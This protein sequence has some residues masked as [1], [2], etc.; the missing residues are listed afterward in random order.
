[1][2]SWVLA[3]Q[4]YASAPFVVGSKI[5]ASRVSQRG[6]TNTLITVLTA[7]QKTFASGLLPIQGSCPS[8]RSFLLTI[9]RTSLAERGNPSRVL[10]AT[11][12]VMVA[13]ACFRRPYS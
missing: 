5:S 7:V 2:V 11:L 13:L 9:G 10:L 1:M 8:P 4:R 12:P 3:P 6:V